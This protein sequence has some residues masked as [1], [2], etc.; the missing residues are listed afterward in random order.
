MIDMVQNWPLPAQI[1]G[2]LVLGLLVLLGFRWFAYWSGELRRTREVQD[3]ARSMDFGSNP[4]DRVALIHTLEALNPEESSGKGVSPALKNL[5]HG[6][7]GNV[8][9]TVFDHE[10]E[11]DGA[12]LPVRH[13]AVC[14]QDDA[15]DL[16]RFELHPRLPPTEIASN[17]ELAATGYLLRTGKTPAEQARRRFDAVMEYLAE[18]PGWSLVGGGTVL[19]CF[20]AGRRAS[21]RAWPE[22]VKEAFAIHRVFRGS[23]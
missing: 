13:T 4:Q 19:V 5:I 16:P 12:T 23:D 3:V 15:M 10:M 11:I 2:G 7:V 1:L 21:P 9:V 6:R 22:L 20:K 14:L 18:H 17:E 8:S